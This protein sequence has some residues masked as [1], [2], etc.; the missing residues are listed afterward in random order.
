MKVGFGAL[1]NK[2]IKKKI[3]NQILYLVVTIN[4]TSYH[5]KFIALFL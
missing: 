4:K 3:T 2:D 1:I 5:Y